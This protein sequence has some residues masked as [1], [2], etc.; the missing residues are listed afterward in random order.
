MRSRE[1]IQTPH[2]ENRVVWGTHPGLISIVYGT[3]KVV[4]LPVRMTQVVKRSRPHTMEIAL[5]GAPNR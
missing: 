1:V 4:P 3:T 2:N 5:C